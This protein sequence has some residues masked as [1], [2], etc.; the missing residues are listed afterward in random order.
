MDETLSTQLWSIVF[1]TAK[2]LNVRLYVKEYR[3]PK[4]QENDIT[5]NSVL[6]KMMIEELASLLSPGGIY[7]VTNI[8]NETME[9]MMI[10]ELA[11]ALFI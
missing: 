2:E 9:I 11:K 1:D 7:N 6:H 10:E 8:A 3:K 5:M 4:L